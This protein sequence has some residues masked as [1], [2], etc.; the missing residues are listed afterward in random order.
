MALLIVEGFSEETPR[1][2]GEGA[3]D[4]EEADGGDWGRSAGDLAERHASF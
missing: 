4:W 1:R 3:A 2:R